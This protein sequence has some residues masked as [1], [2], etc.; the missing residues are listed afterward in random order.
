MYKR[1]GEQVMVFGVG[2]MV[3]LMLIAA[4]AIKWQDFLH[5]IMP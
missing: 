1:T 2:A 4:L 3:S 5:R